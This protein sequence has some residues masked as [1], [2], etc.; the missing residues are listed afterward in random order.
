MERDCLT[1]EHQILTENGFMF[2]SDMENFEL[3][4]LPLI[5]G[6]DSINQIII[7]EKAS[8]LIIKQ[9]KTQ[10]MI[11]VTQEAEQ[12][13]WSSNA[14]MYGRTLDIKKTTHSNGLSFVVT[15]THDL[16]YKKGK[17]RTRN[18][19]R[20]FIK[21]DGYEKKIEGKRYYQEI[22]YA[23]Y[24]AKTLLEIDSTAV[25][26]LSAAKNGVSI[27]DSYILPYIEVLGLTTETEIYFLE[28]YGYWLGDGSLSFKAGGGRDT[29]VFSIVKPHDIEWLL[30]IFNKL[31]FIQ[32]ADYMISVSKQQT[33]IE[34]KVPS[35]VNM[36]HSEYRT[37][38]FMGNT[39]FKRPT[40]LATRAKGIQP[41]ERRQ[42]SG[43]PDNSQPKSA[44]WMFEWVWKLDKTRARAI[45]SGL[46][47]ADGSQSKE[48]NIIYTSST[49]FRDEIVR[50]CFHAG[51]SPRFTV[52][53]ISG[54]I[55]GNM[56]GKDIKANFDS[57]K[58]SYPDI[59]NKNSMF[60]KPVIH[61]KRDIKV[62]EYTGRTW[63]VSVPH[64]FII[65]RR[66]QTNSDGIVIKVSAP[67]IMG[68]CMIG[69]GTTQF[70]NER[71]FE[72]SDKYTV[73]ICEK[74]G[75][76]ATTPTTCRACETDQ[77][78]DIKLPYV[79]KLVLQE[80]N[81]MLIKTKITAKK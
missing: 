17:V 50:L 32:V 53:Y 19:G 49:K 2:L 77:V 12:L 7:Y 5:A 48:Q 54:D 6:Y 25:K 57:W 9:A 60:A 66:A 4:K 28:L 78:V 37:K 39:L 79:S 11:E 67:I 64:T 76:F 63:C 16:Y 43:N 80:L 72:C 1:E 35:Y 31:G 81:A 55:R 68:N 71:L 40:T 27:D 14:D 59:D 22:E 13:R 15:P 41:C 69:H 20:E 8:E 47:R 75:N 46:R 51:Y 38:Y 21:W 73:T 23:K 62:I 33:N 34:I 45:I 36:F 52:V 74:C 30:E 18:N 70:L 29:I 56:N 58:I 61:T 24:K 65:T 44:K 42:I 10:Q 26:F 3:D